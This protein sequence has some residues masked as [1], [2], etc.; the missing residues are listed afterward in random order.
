M[1]NDYELYKLKAELCKAFS[2]PKSLMIIKT[3]FFM[4]ASMLVPNITQK[5]R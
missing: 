5:Q 2:D 4:P 3:L 1:Q